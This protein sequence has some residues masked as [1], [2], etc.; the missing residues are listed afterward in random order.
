MNAIEL[1]KKPFLFLGIVILFGFLF[2]AC[3]N[4]NTHVDED[5]IHQQ[6]KLYMDGYNNKNAQ[7]VAELHTDDVF[8]MP[9]NS[10][11]LRNKETVK[12][13]VEE[14]IQSG[15]SNL[16]FFTLDLKVNGDYAYEVGMSTMKIGTAIDTGK[17]IVVWEKQNDGE[18]LIKADIWNTNLPK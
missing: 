15:A 8:V 7:M 18:W 4:Q 10:Q 12:N 1:N 17:Y 14:D 11:I 5:L 16:E 3:S 6:N 9:P 2:Q 13:F